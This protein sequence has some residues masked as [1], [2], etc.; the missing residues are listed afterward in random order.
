MHLSRMSQY[1]AVVDSGRLVYDFQVSYIL[2]DL[3]PAVV[4]ILESELLKSPT[5]TVKLSIL[6]SVSV[7]CFMYFKVLLLG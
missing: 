6:L 1:S 7:V 5:I 2:L 3:L 4:S